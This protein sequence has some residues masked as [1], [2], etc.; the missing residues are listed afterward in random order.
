MKL[1]INYQVLFV[2]M[3][4]TF[5]CCGCSYKPTLGAQVIA[6]VSD[7]CVTGVVVN[8]EYAMNLEETTNPNQ[9]YYSIQTGHM[10][11]QQTSNTEADIYRTLLNRVWVAAKSVRPLN[12][13]KTKLNSHAPF[14]LND[15]VRF[16][17]VLGSVTGQVTEVAVGAAIHAALQKKHSFC[18]VHFDM[19]PSTTA[20]VWLD[21]SLLLKID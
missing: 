18:R 21:S 9:V 3:C 10:V 5:L 17:S 12:A 15:R 16:D 8:V 7:I 11:N 13:V 2:I 6:N 14:K 1:K 4:G 19:T 20:D